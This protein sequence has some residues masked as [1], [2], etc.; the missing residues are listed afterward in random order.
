[1]RKFLCTISIIVAISAFFNSCTKSGLEDFTPTTTV[2]EDKDFIIKTTNNTIVCIK[3]VEN[4]IFTQTFVK[5]LGAVNGNI[6]NQNWVDSLSDALDVA[7]GGIQFD[8]ATDRFLYNN[9]K[10]TY[11][12]NRF[13]K[14]FI[15]TPSTT[16]SVLFPSEPTQL[17][18]NM[19]FKFTNYTDGLY[20]VNALNQ[21][22]PTFAKA[23]MD[24]NGEE[25]MKV[26]YNGTFSSG[27]FPSPINVVLNIYLKPHN[28]KITVNRITNLQFGFKIE[29]GGDCGSVTEGKVTFLNDDYNNLDVEQDLSNVQL[30]YTKA[31][32]S[33]VNNWNAHQYYQ[34]TNPTTN[35]I[36]STFTSVMYN[37]TEKIGELKFKDLA[38]GDRK[39]FIYYRDGTSDNVDVYTNSFITQLKNVLRPYFGND[40]DDW[41]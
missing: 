30:T 10:G 34:F 22:L 27:S 25:I 4:G 9:I 3:G 15:K 5:F 1:M 38:N 40:V 17:S 8:S 32:L 18:N 28:Y 12:W 41:F 7:T 35:N 33:I 2:Q 14:T 36:N 24:K 29:L 23:S 37:G 26:D 19:V 31:P 16:M 39:V 6:N 13:T 20:Q 11:T 21:Y